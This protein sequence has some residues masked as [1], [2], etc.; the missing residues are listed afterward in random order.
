MEECAICLSSLNDTTKPVRLLNE[1]GHTFHM[2]CIDRWNEI[3]T[4]CP[5]CRR[6]LY[7]RSDFENL[8]KEINTMSG[9][10]I[11]YERNKSNHN[12]NNNLYHKL[13]IIKNMLLEYK[14]IRNNGYSADHLASDIGYLVSDINDDLLLTTTTTIRS[15]APYD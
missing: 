2:L 7:V 5:L 1:C 13:E 4:N 11:R 12:N 15:R 8:A 3:H 10:R 6:N 9:F 14:T